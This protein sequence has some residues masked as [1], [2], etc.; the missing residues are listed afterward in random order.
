MIAITN[1]LGPTSIVINVVLFDALDKPA[2]QTMINKLGKKIANGIMW[3]AKAIVAK[4]AMDEDDGDENKDEFD[5]F[6][7]DSD[8][9]SEDSE[10]SDDDDFNLWNLEALNS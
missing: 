1:S 2:T 8:D 7:S 9:E 3:E 4:Q 6:G 10:D 5:L